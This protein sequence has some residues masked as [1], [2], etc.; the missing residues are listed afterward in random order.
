MRTLVLI[1]AACLLTASALVA[2]SIG[3]GAAT[4]AI[5][6]SF[7][8]AYNRGQFPLL[9]V[10]PP[11]NDVHALGTPGLVQEFTSKA[12]S[13]LKYAL[14][15]PDPNAPV[16]QFDTLQIYSDLYTLFTSVGVSTA[17]YPTIDTTACPT[18]SYGVCN[19]QLFT[20]NYA[21]FVYSSPTTAS[22]TLADPFYTRWNT[23]G[24]IGGSF[25]AA[26]SGQTS[27]TS[28]FT[29]VAGTVQTFATG[30]IY[31]YPA[32]STTPTVYGVTEPVLDA[33]TGAGGFTT[34]GFPTSEAF[35]VSAATGLM[36]QA[37]ENGR[38][39]WTGTNT[40]AVLF[41]VARVDI[42]YASLGQYF[43]A[44]GATAT[45]TATTLDTNGTSVMDRTVTWS[46][47]NGSVVS[48]TPNGYSAIL[49]AVGSGTANVYVTSEGK[50]SAP[51]V[52][53]VGSVCCAIGQGAPTQAITLAFQSAVTRN[54][55]SV[56]FPV[57]T[58]VSRAGT[59]YIQNLT[60][61]GTPP[62][63]WT[64]AEADGSSTAYILTG[65]IYSAYI[66]AGG[67][68]GSLGYPAS[69]PLP[70]PVQKFASGAAL[71]GSPAMLVA[72]PVAAK[73]FALG[74]IS[75]GAGAPA[76]APASFTSFSGIAGV[77]EGFANGQIFGITSG[78]QSGQAWFSTGLILAR[79]LALSGPAG[80][81]GVPL[82][83]VFSGSGGALVE[84]FEGGYIDLQPG[85]SAAVEHFNP[86]TPSLTTLPS[87]VVP[88]GR[89]HV[90]ATGFT[91][92]ATI[93]FTVTGQP[94][95]SVKP[96]TGTFEWDIV[97]PQGAKPGTVAIQATTPG[98]SAAASGSYT[99][100]P[101]AAL[102]PTLTV[103]SGDRQTGVPG[104]LLPSPI[105]AVLK[106]SSGSPIAGVPIV[107]SASPGA[108]A[109]VAAVTDASGRAAV[110]FRM[111]AG[112]GVAVGSISAGGQTV[113]FSALASSTSLTGFPVFPAGQQTPLATSLAAVLRFYQNSGTLLAPSGMAAPD[114]LT[115][116]LTTQNG[117][118]LSETGDSIA[119]PWVAAQFAGAT[120]NLE[121]ATLNHVRDLLSVGTP[122]VLNLNL[123]VNGAAAGGNSVDATGVN[124]DGSI[125]IADPNPA[126]ARTSLADYLNGFSAQ[127][128][129]V[130]ATLGSVF[131]VAP[132]AAVSGVS[133][134][135][136]ASVLSAAAATS[137]V[138]G[139]CPSVDLLGP[140]GGGV[141]FQYCDGS[142]PLYETDFS[143]VKGATVTDLT[144][145][146]AATIP[147]SGATWAISRSNGT[148]TVKPLSL[149][150]GAV[151]DSAGFRPAVSPGGLFTIF[152]SGFSGTPTVTV[153][154][155]AAQVL[156]SFPFQIN[157]VLPAATP[158]GNAALQVTG[159]AGSATSTIAV[160]PVSPGIFLLGSQGAILNPDG[161]LNSPDSPAQRGQFVSLYCSGLGATS[162]KG[163]LQQANTTPS[164]TINNVSA[165][166]SYAGLVTGF[167]GLY[168]VNV[169]IPAAV[170]NRCRLMTHKGLRFRDA[171]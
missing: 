127:G 137:S 107:T 33:F 117:F 89:V 2:V 15:K 77:A 82:S 55:L 71:A 135:T 26:T 85:A 88:G 5:Q 60:G 104:A 56:A 152:G 32:S 69:D 129:T 52:V 113:S 51:L 94:A 61:T 39:E 149:S 68:T 22:F 40:P 153:A 144:G 47:T 59:G 118:V 37:F 164:V 74:G 160:T 161:T 44:P 63:T 65:S 16:A 6:Q 23:G 126:L 73:W 86:R 28:S 128:N 142:A 17:G 42:T 151:A 130:I 90:S 155:R 66:A 43:S 150:I 92:A 70:G 41:P 108:V 83:D 11:I 53:T 4:P 99:I 134:F 30:S 91:P 109:L 170:A 57:P 54:Q 50:T 171:T 115:Q 166:P 140:S 102:L 156:A 157:A 10:V 116:Y 98:T 76:T 20:K 141:R 110:M 133:P 100:T 38:I 3:S 143:A 121:T 81:L 12:N 9:V 45:V 124:A 49:T 97:V 93:A 106:D 7:V 36:R 112:P 13:N 145:G 162:L 87:T 105:V 120:L 18:G 58:P 79:Y 84:N 64:V 138:N 48:V 29:K 168:Q 163:G 75:T 72:A 46:S 96:A 35:Q 158:P 136:V 31:S 125:A 123:T 80:A 147:A 14:V 24:G 111:P 131:S 119:N 62:A 95:F 19:Y 165:V 146:A 114:T 21:M 154:G 169:T 27:V 25:G 139:I 103:V 132:A 167:V 101:V 159:P 34:L 148:L 1:S 67:F 8:N 78:S 122:V